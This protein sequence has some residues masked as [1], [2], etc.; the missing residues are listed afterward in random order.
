MFCVS[1]AELT[2]LF[3]CNILILERALPEGGVVPTSGV[4][5][6]TTQGHTADQT[7]GQSNSIPGLPAT[8]QPACPIAGTTI[9]REEMGLRHLY[10]TPLSRCR[11][12]LCWPCLVLGIG[13]V[14]D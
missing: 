2:V 14:L 8:P 5:R 11:F 12:F 7:P 13:L 4:Q 1:F 6:W 9:L 10:Q 3:T